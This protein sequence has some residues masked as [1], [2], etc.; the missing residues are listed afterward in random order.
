MFQIVAEEGMKKAI[1]ALFIFSTL[2]S[3]QT[4]LDY[5]GRPRYPG[6]L[7]GLKIGTGYTKYLGEFTDGLTSNHFVFGAEFGFCPC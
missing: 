1:V 4:L 2:A 5:N 3:A 6:G 7:L